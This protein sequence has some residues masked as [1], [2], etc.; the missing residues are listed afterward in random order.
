MHCFLCSV[1]QDFFNLRLLVPEAFFPDHHI[2]FSFNRIS[3]C[4]KRFLP[5]NICPVS[6][7]FPLFRIVLCSFSLLPELFFFF[8]GEFSFRIGFCRLPYLLQQD[9]RHFFVFASVKLHGDIS[10]QYFHRK[11]RIQTHRSSS[12]TASACPVGRHASSRSTR[13]SL[14]IAG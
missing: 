13:Y 1:L 3:R 6:F 14:L 8:S 12:I 11:H 2:I 7:C 10:C 4:Y 9:L 5:K